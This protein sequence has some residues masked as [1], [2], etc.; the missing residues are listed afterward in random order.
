MAEEVKFAGGWG[1]VEWT[2]GDVSTKLGIFLE[3]GKGVVCIP[4]LFLLA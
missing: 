1:G 4:V 2:A 3:I